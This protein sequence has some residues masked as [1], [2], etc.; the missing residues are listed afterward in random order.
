M[1]N[2]FSFIVSGII[3]ISF[4]VLLIFIVIFYIMAP[5]P[6][7]FNIKPTS[8]TIELDMI[9]EKSDKKMVEK[10]QE[11]KIEKEEV[12][13]KT[14]SAADEKKPDLKSLFANVKEKANQVAKEEVNNVK[15]S[16]DPKR[17]KSKFEK[18]KKS[19]NIKIDKLLDD[20]KT[21]TNAKSTNS[22]KGEETDE[23][24]SQVSEL[25]SV[26][27][28]IGSGLKA[29]VLVM[30]D[31]NGKFDYRFVTKSGDDAFDTSL[32]GFLDEQKNIVYPKPTKDKAVRINVDFKSEG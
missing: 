6:K 28:P 24:F 7:T 2:R 23:Y 25:L 5:T 16:M 22:A 21:T 15:K 31:L 9:V 30:I 32:R 1:Q 10:K 8:T 19:S 14:A 4:Y 3:A 17:F 20:E 13:E 27:M 18:E 12:Q 29:V 11:K 26:W